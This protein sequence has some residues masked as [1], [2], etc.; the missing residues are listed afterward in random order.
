MF[1]GFD[2]SDDLD[3]EYSELEHLIP[4]GDE[5]FMVL[6]AH[7]LAEQAL[8]EF[9]RQRVVDA[10]FEKQAL[11]E[12]SPCSQGIGLILLAHGLSLRDEVPHAHAEVIWSGLRKL[13]GIRNTLAHELE[14][15]FQK[16][17]H[18]MGDFI[19][20]VCSEMLRT[21]PNINKAFR[22]CAIMLV[23]YLNIDRRPF[24]VSDVD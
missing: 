3:A 1:K 8:V 9:V 14:P 5:A 12:K 24:L 6:K 13:N 22:K 18:R 7:L 23:L 4:Y 21:E 2:G 19:N 20:A 16:L 17:Q 15:N 11:E 10:K